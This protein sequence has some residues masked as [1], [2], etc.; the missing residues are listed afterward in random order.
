MKPRP[1][2]WEVV[3]LGEVAETALGKM[4]DKG[5][6]KGHPHVPYLRNVNVQWGRIDTDDVLTME[7][8]D[9]ARERFAVVRGDLLVCE[10]GEVGRAA[11]WERDHTYM[12]YQK[13]LHRIRPSD[14][15]DSR[16]L[17]YTLEHAATTGA[18]DPLTTG[19]TIKHLPQQNLRRLPL[20]LPPIDEQRRIVE[21]LEDHLSRLDAAERSL[22]TALTRLNRMATSTLWT[23]THNL[24]GSRDL[25]LTA[26]AEVRLGRQR[27]PQNHTGDRMRPYLRAANVDWGVLRLDDVKEMQFSEAEEAIYHLE[28]DDIL[29]VEASG[30][31][32][33]VGK[34]ALYTGVPKDV[35]FQNTLLRVRCFGANPAFV[36]KYLLAEASAGRFLPDSRGVGIN[37]LSRAR[38]AALRIRLPD[39]STQ[40]S[41]A[42][43]TA[44]A[45]ECAAHLE[46]AVDAQRQRSASLRRSLL[47]AAFSGQLANARGE[48]RLADDDVGSVQA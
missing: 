21:I 12:A 5:R 22:A 40:A 3:T 36:Q 37:H 24:P 19:S 47:A 17:R 31:A 38:L 35:C 9:D 29:L 34:S 25:P 16:F 10:G 26:I 41:V 44:E 2:G 6:P 46:Q 20:W 18:L 27:S 42:H 14:R 30:S 28:P 39:G 8:A 4:L 43:A 15:L 11:I 48:P 33:E 32:A 13:A 7:L 45:L 1:R 23:A